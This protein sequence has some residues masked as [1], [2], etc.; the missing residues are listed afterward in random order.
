M[1]KEHETITI[2]ARWDQSQAPIRSTAERGLLLDIEAPEVAERGDQERAPVNIALVIDRSG[3]MGGDPLRAALE[4]AIGVI[5]RLRDD[6]FLSL[7]CYDDRV[8]VL[9]D[10]QKMSAQKRERA[11]AALRKIRSGATTDLARGWLEGARCVARAM[12]EYGLPAGHVIL[13]SDGHANRGECDPEKLA[14]LSSGLAER[15]VT[16]TCVGIGANYSLLQLAAIAEAGQGELHQSSE[17]SEIVEVV[18]GELGEQV[19]IFGRDFSISLEGFEDAEIRQLTHYRQRAGE[20]ALGALIGGQTRQLALLVEFPPA[21][22]A[23]RITYRA[24]AHWRKP[25]GARERQRAELR[26]DF[27]FVDPHDFNP[28]ERDAEVARTIAEIWMARQGYDAMLLN[29]RGRFDDAVACFD[30]AA[31][32]FLRMVEGLDDADNFRRR[33]DRIRSASA[34]RWEGLSKKEAAL[35]ARKQIR[36]KLDFRAA[37]RDRDWTDI[38]DD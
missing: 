36:S 30:L 24:V 22:E 31:P 32:S 2:R 19:A 21:P 9:I 20:I 6:D 17:P 25:D 12:D 5:E 23:T 1:T 27:D 16:T 14:E 4:A 8:N 15:H 29:E 34:H 3:S 35:R 38:D 26:F 18:L 10:A 13:L 11:V 28:E 33:R 37:H 7:V